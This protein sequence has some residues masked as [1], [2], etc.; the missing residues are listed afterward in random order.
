MT[1]SEIADKVIDLLRDHED[2]R[3]GSIHQDPYKSDFFRLFAEAYNAGMMRG[4]REVLYA[5]ALTSILVAR[6]PELVEGKTWDAL[7]QFWSEWTYA[8]DHSAELQ[9]R[10]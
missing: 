6:A 5:D 3:R 9:P 2:K 8:W 1:R 7:Y 10:N 4:E